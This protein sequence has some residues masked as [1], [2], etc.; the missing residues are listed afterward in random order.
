MTTRGNRNAFTLVELL[1]VIV[2][3]AI[4]IGLLVPAVQ[5]ARESARR[6]DCASNMRQIALAITQF[7][8]D[9][10]R[11]PGYVETQTVTTFSSRQVVDRPY[12]FALAK[13][14]E[15]RDI[16]TAY[17]GQ[18]TPGLTAPPEL[19]YLPLVLCP[20][21]AD[22]GDSPLHFVLNTGT[23]DRINP[24]TGLPRERVL[25]NGVFVYA[26]TRT[27]RFLSANGITDGLGTTLA[28]SENIQAGDWHDMEEHLVGFVWHDSFSATNAS[29]SHMPINGD[30]HSGGDV[31]ANVEWARPS[32]YH[33]GMVNAAFLDSHVRE[34]SDQIAYH[35][36]AQLMTSE[37]ADAFGNAVGLQVRFYTLTEADYQ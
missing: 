34:I 36:L 27:R 7:E 35:V 22:A 12:I 5:A 30:V 8:G 16:F 20:S 31:A 37:G 21:N 11:Y 25:A 4:L 32:S 1:V 19:P 2:I 28:I 10:N 15:R 23:P 3:I 9:H 29:Q 18:T 14:L 24:A 17:S 13:L 33:P 6:A 26:P